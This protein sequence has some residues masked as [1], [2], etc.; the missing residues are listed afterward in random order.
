MFIFGDCSSE[1][2]KVLCKQCFDCV[3]MSFISKYVCYFV[4]VWENGVKG[5][6]VICFVVEKD[7]LFSGIEIM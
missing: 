3:I 6:V 7:G 2:S 1:E 5:I 4:I